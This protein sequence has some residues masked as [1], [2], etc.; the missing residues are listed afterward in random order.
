MGRLTT[1]DRLDYRLQLTHQ[2]LE[3]IERYLLRAIAPRLGGV[4]VHLNQQRIRAHRHR[5]F[6]EAADEIRPPTALAGINHY[7]AM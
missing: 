2:F 4:G 5:A 6:A 1:P 3:A 7:R